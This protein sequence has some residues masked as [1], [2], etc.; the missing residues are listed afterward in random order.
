MEQIQGEILIGKDRQLTSDSQNIT[1]SERRTKKTG[2][3]FWKATN[4]FAT[5]KEALHFLVE[6]GIRDYSGLNKLDKKIDEL[7]AMIENIK[8]PIQYIEKKVPAT[9]VK[10][11]PEAT[12][13]SYKRLGRKQV[14]THTR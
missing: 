2:E 9:P 14:K 13:P 5:I 8:I 1:L 10:L 11:S 12:S 6:Q 4:Y 3:Y 7:H